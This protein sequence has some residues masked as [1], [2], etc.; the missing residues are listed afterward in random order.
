[1]SFE[2]IQGDALI[3]MPKLIERGVKVNASITDEPYEVTDSAWDVLIPL[4]P[5]WA[6]LK[7]L[8]MRGGA[9][10]LF[11]SQPCTSII[12]AS[13]LQM[14]KHEWIWEK[15]RASNFLNAPNQPMKIHESIIVFGQG[16]ITYN[17]QKT[18]GH[19][20]VNFARRK[21]N[22]SAAYGFHREAVNNAGDTTRNPKSIQYFRCVD[23]CSP[24]RY[25]TN[26]KPVE[27]MRYLVR[28]YTNEGDTV[29]DFACGSGSTG[30]ACVIENRNF[31]GIEKDANYCAIAEARI[32]RASGIPCDIPKP[33]RS[34][35][36]LP[37]FPSGV[38]K[39][40]SLLNLSSI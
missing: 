21:A 23:N 7:S 1:M 19:E 25:H 11:G 15:N 37:L 34:E 39:D 17:P 13:N 27:L 36:P 18:T 9:N 30:V 14:F 10:V 22:S 33:M 8:V 32:K 24:E 20:P 6:S 40:E 3:E 28:T 26:Q 16:A 4:E 5:M 29:L 12:I 38:D 35:K 31:I 2:V